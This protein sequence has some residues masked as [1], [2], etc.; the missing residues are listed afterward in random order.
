MA[1]TLSTPLPAAAS[2]RTTLIPNP[3]KSYW[4]RTLLPLLHISQNTFTQRA[5]PPLVICTIVISMC[6]VKLQFILRRH[7]WLQ[8]HTYC[9][10]SLPKTVPL[11]RLRGAPS[12]HGAN[13]CVPEH[14]TRPRTILLQGQLQWNG[15]QNWESN[16]NW[17][18]SFPTSERPPDGV[19][20]NVTPSD[21][22]TTPC[23]KWVSITALSTNMDSVKETVA[24][25]KNTIWFTTVQ[26]PY[27]MV[28]NYDNR[29][30]NAA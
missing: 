16:G 6:K 7:Q 27:S 1:P 30:Q 23:T 13:K 14:T 17:T 3:N 11:H 18:E 21:A 12:M 20:S 28:V 29:S 8:P 9:N 25:A 4:W 5:V 26:Q 10:C 22:S 15:L 24:N 19:G 2:A